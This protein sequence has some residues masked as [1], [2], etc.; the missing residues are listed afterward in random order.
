MNQMIRLSARA[1]PGTERT[2]WTEV[3]GNVCAK[4][5]F[6]VLRDVTQRSAEMWSIVMD[7][8]SSS[9]RNSPTWTN[10]SV[11]ANATPDTVIR[12]RRRSWSRLFVARS[13]TSAP[14]ADESADH[15]VDELVRDR[16][17]V[18]PV[19]PVVVAL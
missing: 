4:S 6:G 11:T 18:A 3:S 10:T 5:T 14:L 17:R 7:A 19:D 9:P 1:T 15:H 16:L 2:R 12:K 8:L 13:T